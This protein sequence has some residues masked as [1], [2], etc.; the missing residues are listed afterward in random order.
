[1]AIFIE[2]LAGAG[3][4]IFF[5]WVLDF[6]E[7][8]YTILGVGILLSIATYLIREEVAKTREKLSEKY[9]QAH[10][11]TFS[12]AKIADPECKIKAQEIIVGAKKTI[13]LLQQ[14]YFPMDEAEYYLE[15]AKLSDHAL[16][17]IKSA[18]PMIHGWGTH[19]AHHNFY[20]ANLR[21]QQ[22]GLKL[23]RLFVIDRGELDDPD[24]QA[25][26]LAHHRDGIEV[27]LAYRH[28]LPVSSDTSGRN[29]IGSYHFAIYDDL[30]ATEV[31]DKPGKYFG[32]K[33][34]QTGEA[35]KYLHMYALMEHGSHPVILEDERIVPASV[36]LS[37]TV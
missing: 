17:E 2:F 24:V 30:V 31:F 8:A 1:M 32:Q 35:A 37:A 22:R 11:I 27:R 5:H 25:V 7:A 15:S 21:A 9:D 19:G 3:L 28:E 29:I 10:E 26:L 14:G 13:E 18:D 12:I 4:A 36:G 6:H 34:A 16:R 20:Q 23:T 33:T